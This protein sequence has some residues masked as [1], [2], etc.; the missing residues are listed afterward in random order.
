MLIRTFVLKVVN[1]ERKKINPSWNHWSHCR[2][3]WFGDHLSVQG[4]KIV[5]SSELTAAIFVIYLFI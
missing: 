3:N 5:N 4:I 2:G 1:D